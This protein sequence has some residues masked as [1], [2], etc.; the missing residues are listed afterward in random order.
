MIRSLPRGPGMSPSRPEPRVVQFSGMV[1]VV[2]DAGD[3]KAALAA[4]EAELTLLDLRE[5]GCARIG[6]PTD[7]VRARNHAAGR[8]FSLQG[9]RVAPWFLAGGSP[10]PRD[11]SRSG[12]PHGI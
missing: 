6:A 4:G 5:D 7:A 12:E 8:S 2:A 9:F 10:D 1:Q 11:E 3:L